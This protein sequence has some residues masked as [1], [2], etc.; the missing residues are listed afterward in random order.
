MEDENTQHAVI[1]ELHSLQKSV[2][3]VLRAVNAK[4]LPPAS[5]VDA[6]SLLRQAHHNLRIVSHLFE[7]VSVGLR[8]G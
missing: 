8:C 6:L 1:S 3:E 2:E 7:R 4:Q 5:N